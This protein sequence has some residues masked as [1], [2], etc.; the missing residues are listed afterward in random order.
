MTR[1]AQDIDPAVMEVWTQRAAELARVPAAEDEG[2]H[3]ALVVARIGGEMYAFDA[4]YVSDIRPAGSMAHVPR[5]PAWVAGVTAIRGRILSVFDLATYFGLPT[6]KK[7][8]E[9]GSQHLV[10]VETPDME[11]C[12]LV[13]EVVA[14]TPLAMSSL[15]EAAG[16]LQGLPPEYVRGIATDSA[17][18]A[19]PWGEGLLVVLDLPA[20][21]ADRRIVI[22]QEAI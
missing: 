10:A 3:V 21:L 19:A 15:Q 11:L 8:A 2:E 14:V 16:N 7:R 1:P 18:S 4:H 22:D 5:V 6:V 9:Q 12:L 13:D 20:L 17:V